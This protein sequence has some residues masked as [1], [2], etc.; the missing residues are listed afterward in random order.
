LYALDLINTNQGKLKIE[1]L[2]YSCGFN[3]KTSFNKYFKEKTGFTP[4]EYQLQQER[5]T[6]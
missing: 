3:S 1:S 6:T 4:S 5:Q 2:A